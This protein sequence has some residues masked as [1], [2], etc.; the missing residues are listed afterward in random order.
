MLYLCQW[1]ID[2]LFYLGQI[3]LGKVVLIGG[4]I[5]HRLLISYFEVALSHLPFDLLV[6]PF[7]LDHIQLGITLDF[8]ERLQQIH[9]GGLERDC[10]VPELEVFLSQVLPQQ[11]WICCHCGP[12]S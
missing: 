4:C 9:V 10:V 12:T 6:L 1:K 5:V 7:L 8:G 2:L 3:R 11:I